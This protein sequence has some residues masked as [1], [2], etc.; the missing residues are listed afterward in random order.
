MFRNFFK[1]ELG[2]SVVHFH[3]KVIL[4][5][6]GTNGNLESSELHGKYSE[7]CFLIPVSL[8]AL[9]YIP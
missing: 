4:V 5:L 6:L 7:F 8:T 3:C 1:D 2:T 9:S